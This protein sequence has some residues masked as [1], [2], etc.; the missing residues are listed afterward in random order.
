MRGGDSVETFLHPK[1][2]IPGPAN[3]ARVVDDKNGRYTISFPT[4]YSGECDLYIRV[5]GRDTRGSSFVVNFLPKS[6]LLKLNKNVRELGANKG[7]LSH[8]QHG[9]CPWGI[10]VDQYGHIFVADNG[11]HQ[12]HEFDKQRKYIKSFGRQ[13]SG[14]GE[15]HNPAGIALDH[16]NRLYTGNHGNNRIEVVESDGTFVWQIGA[17]HLSQPFGVTVHNKHVFV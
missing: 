2:P 14:N 9:G 10:V 5:N 1:F 15:L 4:T 6:G 13:G 16:D 8:P 7:Y 3:T 17:G 11:N 12:I